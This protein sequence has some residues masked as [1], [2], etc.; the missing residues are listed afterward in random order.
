[1]SPTD[2]P[3][4]TRTPGRP[5]F[6]LLVLGTAGLSWVYLATRPE[7]ERNFAS[8][9]TS[10]LQVLTALLLLLWFLFSRRFSGATRL[11]GLLGVLA[12]GGL[13]WLILRVDGTVD[14]TGLPRLVWR[15]SGGA[16]TR[17]NPPAQASAPGPA[18]AADPRLAGVADVPQ[19][20]GPDR[21]GVVPAASLS[22]DWAHSPPREVWR[23]PI[24]AGWSAFAVVRDRAFT[25]E[26][27]G[28]E[29]L[30][31]CYH[32]FTG[33]M[34][35]SQADPARFFQ[36]QGGEGPRAT[37]TVHEGRVYAYGAT[38]L[39]NCLD[40]ATGRRIWQRAVLAENQL[41]NLEWGLSASP[42]VVDDLVVV[43]GG[44]PRGPVLFAYH[45]LT[46]E[47][48]WKAGD[49]EAS[50]ASPLLAKVAG[51]R[52]ILSHHARALSLHDPKTGA[53]LGEHAW[54]GEKWPKAS[55]PVVVGTNRI[56]L[57][58]GYGMGC[59]LVQAEPAGDGRLQLNEVW[60]GI[61]MKTQFNSA[62]LSGDFLYGLDDGRLACVDVRTGER[63]WKEG[64]YASGQTLL[65]G[66]LVLV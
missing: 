5:W 56:F 55:Q 66:N 23:Q 38:G 50:Y 57:S 37:P 22:R 46:G 49:D 3:A 60:R 12:L 13:A 24:G 6:P 35:W 45:R 21:T 26:Q 28:G 44:R 47:P 34:L 65:V 30:V 41:S 27:R 53:V 42:L 11:R 19:F 29:E 25:Q 32:L 2:S 10:A 7:L 18:P 8:W 36:W 52:M 40:A 54:G 16:R 61:R 15:W 20:F 1:M 48:A 63:R 59:R 14:G 43:T 9:L 4:R 51:R 62:A 58:A 31:T 64:H 39:L 33:R 17:G